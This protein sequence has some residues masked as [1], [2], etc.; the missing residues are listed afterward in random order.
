M[1]KSVTILLAILLVSWFP[2]KGIAF[3]QW[4][5]TGQDKCYNN[6]E[7]IPCP[8]EG[9]LFYGQDAN[10]DRP[11]RSYTKLAYGDVEL[12][13]TATQADGW[14]MTRDNV[15]GLI[16][17]IKTDDGGVHDK[18]NTYT[19][20]DTDPAT[21][22]GDPG[23]CGIGTDTED[24]ITA[25]KDE[26]F[27]GHTDWRLPTI[28]ELSSLVNSNIPYP[29]LTIDA[30]YFPKT[31]TSSYWSSTTDIS[32]HP[33]FSSIFRWSVDFNY[34]GVIGTGYGYS[35][36]LYYL[37]AVRSVQPEKS[38]RFKNNG[39]GT[40][41]DTATGLMW[42][43]WNRDYLSWELAISYCVNGQWAGYDDW[44]LPN[45]N[46]LQ[47]LVDYSHYNPSIDT[48]FFPAM[49]EFLDSSFWSSTTYPGTG[50]AWKVSFIDG[51]ISPIHA[52]GNA[53]YVFPVRSA[54]GG[55]PG[56]LDISP[57]EYNF[58]TVSY[59]RPELDFKV[60]TITNNTDTVVAVDY[61]SLS[62]TNAEMFSIGINLCSA[63][64]L[65]KN[66][67]SC[68]VEIGF[69]MQNEGQGAKEAKLEV[70]FMD[71]ENSPLSAT[72][73]GTTKF[74][75]VFPRLYMQNKGSAV[76]PKEDEEKIYIDPNASAHD[77]ECIPGANYE[78]YLETSNPISEGLH[79]SLLP[80]SNASISSY[81]NPNGFFIGSENII[82][83]DTT[84]V[85]DLKQIAE[86]NC[87]PFGGLESAYSDYNLISL[88]EMK[89]DVMNNSY[90]A[91]V[92]PEPEDI[93][94]TPL[95]ISLKPKTGMSYKEILS[96][97]PDFQSP[98]NYKTVQF[99][100]VLSRLA[101]FNGDDDDNNDKFPE[102]VLHESGFTNIKFIEAANQQLFFAEK[103]NIVYVFFRGTEFFIEN[104]DF[105]Q[106]ALVMELCDPQVSAKWFA[107]ECE[108]GHFHAGFAVLGNLAYTELDP[109]LRAFCTEEDNCHIDDN[110]KDLLIKLEKKLFITGHS[111]GGA[112][113]TVLA[114]KAAADGV[115]PDSMQTYTLAAP[116]SVTQ[117]FA[118]NIQFPNL[119]M[120]T[121]QHFS[122]PVTMVPTQLIKFPIELDLFVNTK[123]VGE[124]AHLWKEIKEEKIPY[125]AG[126]E[127]QAG[128]ALDI[129]LSHHYMQT[130]INSSFLLD[131]TTEY[132]GSITFHDYCIWEP[133]EPTAF[134][135]GTQI[136]SSGVAYYGPFPIE[137]VELFDRYGIQIGNPP[138]QTQ[139]AMAALA[140][141]DILSDNC[142]TFNFSS[143]THSVNLQ[144]ADFNGN[145][146]ATSYDTEGKVMEVLAGYEQEPGGYLF[147][148]ETEIDKVSVCS[149]SAWI[150]RVS[151][152]AAQSDI[153]VPSEPCLL[154]DYHGLSAQFSALQS[155]D[156]DRVFFFDTSQCA[157]YDMVS[158]VKEDRA[159][160]ENHMDY[161]G[162]GQIIGGNGD[163]IIVY[164]YDEA[165]EYIINMTMTEPNNGIT[166][167]E[168]VAITAD[169]V[170]TPLPAL[171]FVSNIDS[172]TVT[173]AIT[174]PDSTDAEVESLIVFWGD[175]NR[176]EYTWPIDP[177]P[178]H[179]YTR[180]G[181]DYHIRV[182]AILTDG[183][184]FNYTFM[185]D[186]ELIV[187]IPESTSEIGTVISAGQVW[188]DRNLGASRVATSSTDSA[189]YG[190]L[191]Q[192]GRLTDGH[193]DRTSATTTTNS[194]SDDPGHDNFITEALYPWDWRVPHNDSLWQG[195]SGANNPCPTGFRLPT[196]EEWNTERVS[197]ASQDS[198]GAFASPLKLVVAGARSA[199]GVE[200]EIGQTG[201]YWTSTQQHSNGGT[202]NK[203]YFRDTIVELNYGH[204]AY[205]HSVRCIKD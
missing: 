174:D 54:Q 182:K 159:C 177:N 195:V 37:R 75:S 127:Y 146:I 185:N 22:G 55:A 119:N 84:I 49:I 165:G 136:N 139:T 87:S 81:K 116:R 147:S 184:Q 175:R 181:S 35:N 138:A 56:D 193:E 86:V 44:R 20:C 6:N 72:L 196:Y 164:R 25:I 12:P 99:S 2:I 109:Y 74:N 167:S 156:T 27:G 194:L 45:R 166:V 190:Y 1:K 201:F 29:G 100:S 106:D 183:E 58:G 110:L 172:A 162:T 62:G 191:Y 135:D 79:Y 142:V 108:I 98:F 123:H 67:G 179:T 24:F 129:V 186:Q 125:L 118:N 70:N 160:I 88:K 205:G 169:I 19:W 9:E 40:V 130:Y 153:S 23:T 63:K 71:S 178:E 117:D 122:D 26:T 73:Q 96:Y 200:Q 93:I 97:T 202:A 131:E 8:S 32:I 76:M 149:D 128:H 64:W 80:D 151:Y 39:D 30:S 91:S 114:V 111:F 95:T 11:S 158:C 180:T 92:F 94:T 69:P 137:D 144:L 43:I 50:R 188:M 33:Y 176:S 82:P 105:L 46:E 102:S 31:I 148:S 77:I 68:T 126:E 38:D 189:A 101:Y 16:W 203:I 145:T 53:N 152:D 168:D 112:G 113:A 134:S 17:E 170:E 10:Y 21:N 163:G 187:S 154:S 15:T 36:S 192:W 42:N 120:H 107:G 199:N 78:L 133:V 155:S 18:D 173:L 157:C 83:S 4:P 34:G 103:E 115:C 132:P 28:K 198:E 121:L 60:F 66:G 141:S 124:K 47:S 143:P 14:I 7:E 51:Q 171:N 197:W 48:S 85:G 89:M 204:R 90:S 150:G 13:D 65:A 104:A 5:D 41:T 59:G 140:L 52:K 61:V 57:T 3:N 161:G